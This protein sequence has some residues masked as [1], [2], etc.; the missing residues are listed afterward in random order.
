MG[1]V[2]LRDVYWV[3]GQK[4]SLHPSMNGAM[5]VIVNHRRKK[6]IAYRRKPPWE[7]PL[8]LLAKTKLS[9]AAEAVRGNGKPF[10]KCCDSTH[11]DTPQAYEADE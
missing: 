10:G 9:N 11:N 5:F 6:P 8:Y 2:S 1:D 7:Q 3:G 4:Q